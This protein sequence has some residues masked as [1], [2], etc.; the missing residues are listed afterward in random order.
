MCVSSS[1]STVLQ[2]RLCSRNMTRSAHWCAPDICHI[3]HWCVPLYVV[4]ECTTRARARPCRYFH[5]W[6][7]WGTHEW[8]YLIYVVCH[9]SCIINS[10]KSNKSNKSTALQVHSRLY[11][12]THSCVRDVC[13]QQQEH[14]PAGTFK[15]QIPLDSQPGQ[16]YIRK[17]NGQEP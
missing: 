14:G 2:A 11:G 10:N 6:H 16:V 8:M 5:I 3:S 17:Q 7:I 12:M 13:Q 1:K 15:V 4:Y 9:M